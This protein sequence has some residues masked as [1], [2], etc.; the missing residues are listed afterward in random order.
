MGPGELE[1]ILVGMS[2][3]LGFQQKTGSVEGF[4]QRQWRLH[5]RADAAKCTFLFK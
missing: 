3:S 1:C 4:L 5:F 2:L